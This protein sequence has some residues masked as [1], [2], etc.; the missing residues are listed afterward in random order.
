M[1]YTRDLLT[2]TRISHRR[3]HIQYINNNSQTY[4][5]HSDVAYYRHEKRLYGLNV[6]VENLTVR[7]CIGTTKAVCDERTRCAAKIHV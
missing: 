6:F 5:K 7:Q 3:R 4:C 1:Q 2:L